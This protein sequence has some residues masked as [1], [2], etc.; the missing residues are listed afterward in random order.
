VVNR[1]RATLLRILTDDGCKYKAQVGGWRSSS[2][3]SSSR[4]RG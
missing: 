1:L 2:S 4:E 3:S